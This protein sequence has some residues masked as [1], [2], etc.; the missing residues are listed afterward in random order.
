MN[1]SEIRAAHEAA[2]PGPWGWFGN[3]ASKEIHLA[4]QN[5]GRIFVLRFKRW[6]MRDAQPMFQVPPAN[7]KM[8]PVTEL[9]VFEKAYR[10]DFHDIDHPDARFIANS[11]EYVQTLLVHIDSLERHLRT[12]EARDTSNRP[13]SRILERGVQL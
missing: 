4:T 6:G 8:V 3:T 2:T 5:R 7:G 12:Y 11:W 1:I 10:R 9:V 13:P